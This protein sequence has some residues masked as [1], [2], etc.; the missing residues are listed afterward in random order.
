V[1]HLIRGTGRRANLI[2]LACR[3]MIE[4]LGAEERVLA[5][6]RLDAELRGVDLADALRPL[7]ALAVLDRI[8]VAQSFL[9]GEPTK[10]EVRAAIRQRGVDASGAEVDQA[11][12]RLMLGYVLLAADDGRLVCP[13]P[14]VREAI[15]RE[16]KLEDRLQDDIDDW[17]AGK[18]GAPP[19]SP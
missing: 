2:V 8:L 17:T 12:D 6:P 18:R 10:E 19:G 9:L 7:R 14:F 5:R 13:V 4:A 16:R 15:E 11:F 3:A 1:E